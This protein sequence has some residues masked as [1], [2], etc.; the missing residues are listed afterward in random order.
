M[1][2]VKQQLFPLTKHF[3]PGYWNYHFELLLQRFFKQSAE[4]KL[5]S[6][7]TSFSGVQSELFKHP[8]KLHAEVCK[9]M[10]STGFASSDLV[11]F[12]QGQGHNVVQSGRGQRCLYMA[13]VKNLAEMSEHYVQC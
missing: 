9:K 2:S 1:H 7:I 10:N 3:H 6:L 13:G 12:K 4:Q 8:I 11:I 5:T